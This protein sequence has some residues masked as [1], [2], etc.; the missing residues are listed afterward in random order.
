MLTVVLLALVGAFGCDEHS[1][2]ER[3]E[4]DPLTTLELATSASGV[5][6][7][8]RLPTI[9]LTKTAAVFGSRT[10][11]PIANNQLANS[12]DH[13]AV[14]RAL[15]RA[16]AANGGYG[17]GVDR[18]TKFGL[19]REVMATGLKAG[20]GALELRINERQS[21]K[22]LKVCAVLGVSKVRGEADCWGRSVV[23]PVRQTT[24]GAASDQSGDDAGADVSLQQGD[25][26]S[27]PQVYA[28]DAALELS[29]SIDERYLLVSV[30]GRSFRTLPLEAST[31][32]AR[33]EHYQLLRRTLLSLRRANSWERRAA[34]RVSDGVRWET[35]IAVLGVLV[36]VQFDHILLGDI[37]PENR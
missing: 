27:S 25:I 31:D 29:F 15:V 18:R 23:V 16:E 13:K 8:E 33:R 14:E 5:G 1:T 37:A 11:A 22:A 2:Q 7:D 21:A 24:D 6:A 4:P 9:W 3:R 30:Q 32:D 35:V 26:E 10:L 17:L 20:A 36:E 34:V 28:W 12:S 19:V